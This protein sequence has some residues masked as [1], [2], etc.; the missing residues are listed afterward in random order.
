MTIVQIRK[1][2]KEK[3]V[4]YADGKSMNKAVAELVQDAPT[5]DSGVRHNQEYANIRI[6][7]E[8]FDRLKRCKEYPNET[9]SETIIRLL[10]LKGIE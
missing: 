3:L 2:V 6:D 8:V 1:E 4:E 10:N 9:H 7:D 5:Y